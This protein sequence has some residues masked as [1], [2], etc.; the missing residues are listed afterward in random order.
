MHVVVCAKL[1]TRPY[2]N[3]G[4]PG[5][6]IALMEVSLGIDC[7]PKIARDKRVVCVAASRLLL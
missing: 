1:L 2:G 4:D 3:T 7:R 6:T 5:V